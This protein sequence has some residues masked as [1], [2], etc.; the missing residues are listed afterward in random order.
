MRGRGGGGGVG[1][2]GFCGVRNSLQLLGQNGMGDVVMPGKTCKRTRT[3]KDQQ[4]K[5]AADTKSESKC[6][7]ESILFIS[8]LF[9]AAAPM[10]ELVKCAG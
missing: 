2:W 7:L 9:V 5:E 1:F 10:N 3:D 4:L 8:A 6:L